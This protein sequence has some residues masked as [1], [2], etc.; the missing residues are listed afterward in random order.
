MKNYIVSL[1]LSLVYLS[2]VA[3]PPYNQNINFAGNTTISGPFKITRGTP[4]SGKIL[5][6]DVSGNA[7]WSSKVNVDSITAGYGAFRIINV[8]RAQVDS[9]QLDTANLTP[10]IPITVNADGTLVSDTSCHCGGGG[11]PAGNNAWVQYNNSGA[12]G[13]DSNFVWDKNNFVFGVGDLYYQSNGTRLLVEDDNQDIQ[14]FTNLLTG[15]GTSNETFIYA[16]PHNAYLGDVDAM[17]N[18]YYLQVD[19]NTP[20]IR[21]NFSNDHLDFNS[22]NDTII[23]SANKPVRFDSLIVPIGSVDTVYYCSCDTTGPSDVTSGTYT[24]TALDSL[25][26]TDIVLKTAQYMRVGSVVTVSGI[27]DFNTASATPWSIRFSVPVA[28]GSVNYYECSGSATS[29]WSISTP[30]ESSTIQFT[31]SPIGATLYSSTAFSGAHEFCYQFT[32]HIN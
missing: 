24:P 16:T 8:S 30:V 26:A 15:V 4:G 25:F 6:S 19:N 20:R 17:Y 32:Y 7:N 29:T 5:T 3:Q 27:I 9:L 18:Y 22:A 11:S 23:I 13:A 1:L 28:P 12:F 31:G 21:L 10:G 14:L 2:A